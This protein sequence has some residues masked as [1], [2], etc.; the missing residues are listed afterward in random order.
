MLDRPVAV[1]PPR[2]LRARRR[3]PA[4]LALSVA[5]IAAG[6]LGGAALYSATGERV[7]VLALARD[8]PAGQQ[9]TAA[10]LTVARIAGDPALHPLDG[11]DLD[12]AVGMRAT[13]DL[14]RGSLLTKADVID[15]LI[16]RPGQ[17]IVGVAAKRTQ[18][19]ATALKPGRQVIVVS[20]P[21]STQ[22][23]DTAPRSQTFTATVVTVGGADTDG[24][25]VVDMAVDEADGPRLAETVAG[26]KFQV[27]LASTSQR[28]GG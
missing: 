26:G 7:A 20:T 23:G 1:A 21:D 15:K 4:V 12:R 5:L 10:D 18:L 27:I 8:V 22:G 14:K 17:Q 11:A 24:T 6:G 28:S 2:A 9:L 16:V 13:N 3:R 25:V 19:P